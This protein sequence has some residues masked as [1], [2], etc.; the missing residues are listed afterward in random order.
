[1]PAAPAAPRQNHV[2]DHGNIVVP[3]NHL[4]AFG[5]K[6]ARLHHRKIAR[7]PVNT[8]VEKT[9]DEQ[10]GERRDNQGFNHLRGLMFFALEYF[11]KLYSAA[12]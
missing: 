1:M 6:R 2:A 9:A 11:K 12:M 3:R 10:A 7:Q 5:A 4:V 8:N